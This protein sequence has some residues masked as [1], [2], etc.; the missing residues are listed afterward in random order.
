M[1]EGVEEGVEGGLGVGCPG[2]GCPFVGREKGP[3]AVEERLSDLWDVTSP[4]ACELLSGG[5]GLLTA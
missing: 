2:G 3:A 5:S 4:L 1:G